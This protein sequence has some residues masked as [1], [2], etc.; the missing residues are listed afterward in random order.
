MGPAV[1]SSTQLDLIRHGEPEGGSKYRG[2]SD[3]PLSA[4]GW[5][6]M[7]AAVGDTASWDVIV[8]SPLRRCLAFAEALASERAL[9]LAVETR[10]KE[11]SFGAW[12]NR[13]KAEIEAADPGSVARF[14]ADPLRCRPEGAEPLADF[15][16]RV[17]EGWN[18]VLERHSGARVLLVTH[19]GVIRM[20]V[21]HVLAAP[22]ERAYRV[23]VPY[24]GVTRVAVRR[25]KDISQAQLLFHAGCLHAP[26]YSAAER[27]SKQSSRLTS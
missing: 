10:L 26:D 6:Q 12:E 20:V 22:L 19:A 4:R 24:A 7:R 16:D 11:V 23:Q 2:Q 3:D 9:P 15:R 21:G 14:Y 25:G 17:I 18:A 1:N 13:T 8:S 27:A 5:E